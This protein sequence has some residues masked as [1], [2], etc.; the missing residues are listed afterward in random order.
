MQSDADVYPM[1][2][3]VRLAVSDVGTSTA[4]Y[5]AL[6]FEVVYSMP[7]MAHVRYR[8]YADVMLAADET[9]PGAGAPRATPRGSGI[10]IYLNV[11]DES[12]DDVAE[13]AHEAA[14]EIAVEP[15]ET[16]WNT[17]EVTLTDPDGYELVFT[18]V[19]DADRSFESVM[20]SRVD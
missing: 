2:L 15:H 20:D 19:V 9:Q 5:E 17:R 10:S 7:V 18:E 1:P 11:A 14:A 16:P 8:R 3:F 6:G 12:V 13:R 4:W